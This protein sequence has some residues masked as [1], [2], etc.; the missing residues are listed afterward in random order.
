MTLNELYLWFD[1]AMEIRGHKKDT[2]VDEIKGQFEWD[3]EQ[4]RYVINNG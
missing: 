3:D 4:G 2:T 1:K